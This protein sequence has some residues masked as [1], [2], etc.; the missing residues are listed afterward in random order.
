MNGIK[1]KAIV[2]IEEKKISDRL[3]KNTRRI[4]ANLDAL[5]MGDSNF[6]IPK[7]TGTLEK[8]SIINTQIGSGVI[9]WRTPYARAQYYGDNLDHSRQLNPNACSRWFEAAKARWLEKWEKFVNDMF[10]S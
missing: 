8:S 3:K 6:F 10:H 1:V 4:Q 5:I 7:K 9:V 2:A